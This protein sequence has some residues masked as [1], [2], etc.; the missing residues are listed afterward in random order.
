MKTYV[1]LY[2]LRG[3]ELSDPDELLEGTGKKLRHVNLYDAGD[4]KRPALRR[5]MKRAVTHGQKG[6][7]NATKRS[8]A[9]K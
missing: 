1:Q 4:L 3:S 6:K 5:L 7:G 9:K 2:F 8:K